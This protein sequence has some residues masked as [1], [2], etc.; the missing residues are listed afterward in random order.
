MGV[1]T[2]ISDDVDIRAKK[3]T[4]EKNGINYIIIQGLTHQVGIVISCV[5]VCVCVCV[6]RDAKYVRQK[7]I[8]VKEE[9]EN[10]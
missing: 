6:N 5:C 8:Q 9:A 2:L 3:I 4:R 10:P 1:I 7:L